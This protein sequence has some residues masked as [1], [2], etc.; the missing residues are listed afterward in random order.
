MLLGFHYSG[1][2]LSLWLIRCVWLLVL[3]CPSSAFAAI[4]PTPS[5][6]CVS[7]NGSALVTSEFPGENT[8]EWYT[9]QGVLLSIDQ[10]S[11][12]QSSIFNLCPGVYQVQYTNGDQNN[13]EWFS[14]DTPAQSAGQPGQTEIC[15]NTGTVN[16][17]SLI[18]GTPTGNG[19]WTNPFGQPHSGV[20]DSNGEVG[21]FY[22][23]TL[24]GATCNISSGVWVNVIQN[25]NPGLSATYLIC[26]TYEPFALTD[27]LAGTPEPNGQWFN[28]NQDPIDGNYYP[29]LQETELFTYMI[30][31]VEGCPAVF[32][33]LLVIENL[34]PNP[35]TDTEI[36]VCPGAV[37][38]DLTSYMEG[39]PDAGGTW[40][41]D[42]FNQIAIPFNPADNDEGLYQYIVPG[43]TPC[44]SQEAFLTLTYTDGI[45]AGVNS[46]LTVCEN[47]NSIS[48]TNSLDGNPSPG[49]Y[50]LDEDGN[51][52]DDIIQ[53]SAAPQ[54]VYTYTVE[55]V[56]C[57]PETSELVLTV[58]YL[59][60]AG[61]GGPQSFCETISEIDPFSLLDPLADGNG[62]W[63]INGIGLNGV[64][65]VQPDQQYD[66]LYS[67]TGNVCP[68]DQASYQI[69]VDP[70]P[71]ISGDPEL[72]LCSNS[73]VVSL[74]PYL[75]YDPQF[76][77][78]WLDSEGEV[79]DG[80]I[81]AGAAQ[82]GIYTATLYSDNACPDAQ[83]PVNLQIA[84][85]AFEDQE[86]MQ[87]DCIYDMT[88]DLNQLLPVDIPAGGVWESEE[89]IVDPILNADAIG[90]GSYTY[91]M[92]GPEACGASY[93]D[94]ELELTEA[95]S[96]GIGND[97]S[98]CSTSDVIDLEELVDGAEEG[99]YWTLNGEELAA[100]SFDPELE[101]SGL[102]YYTIPANGPCPADSSVV[103]IDVQEGLALSAGADQFLCEFDDPIVVGS[104]QCEECEFSWTPIDQIDDA[105]IA[106]PM[107]T[108]PAVNT[109][110]VFDLVV[111]ASN[112][113]CTALDEVAVTVY[114]DPEL[115]LTIPTALC[116]ED[117]LFA[118]AMGADSF[119]WMIEGE[120]VSED[121]V[122]EMIAD[123]PIDVT[124]VGTSSFGCSSQLESS[125]QVNPLIYPEF[126]LEPIEG[127]YPV[128][129]QLE[130]PEEED[131]VN[132]WWELGGVM[133]PQPSTTVVLNEPGEYDLSLFSEST[134]GC[135]NEVAQESWIE[136][137]GYPAVSFRFPEE[138]S[139][140]QTN[141]SFENLSEPGLEWNWDFGALGAS[142]E[143]EPQFTFP[144]LPDTGYLVCL[145]GTN[146]DGCTTQHCE[147][148]FFE[149]DMLV[150]VP[151]AFTPDLDGVNDVFRPY[152]SGVKEDTYVFQI[153]NRW[154]EMIFETN[155]VNAFW[156]GSVKGGS[157]FAPDGVY[158]WKIEVE[159]LYSA[160]KNL[161]QGHLTLLR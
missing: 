54:Q 161:F 126:N 131:G 38:F 16:L 142:N 15:S 48:L 130:L 129:V 147:S 41:D 154:G 94:L 66:L 33:T 67:V 140:Q 35:G 29:D 18:Q 96:P 139:F 101:S 114:P 109:T 102:Y 68:S 22:T 132:Y 87:Q 6:D 37:P 56:G 91:S 2:P 24:D 42:Q 105:S 28:S 111:E 62:E 135:I 72:A 61:A 160:E 81:D 40:Y 121:A 10:N 155:D 14:I 152:V 159:D 45:D 51:E 83:W 85:P 144:D 70:L 31:T 137:F 13:V 97:V 60:N 158:T 53:I 36:A 151:N 136:V 5:D 17:Q 74:T 23:Y 120:L 7:C 49:G 128:T 156:N 69:L 124:L 3:L 146:S 32:S 149:G 125:V 1:R 103:V 99:G 89:G 71:V 143:F 157:Y 78:E 112:G 82:E 50:W 141:V 11:F 133:Y 8:Y 127:C 100:T 21:G 104:L 117:V 73:G 119:E 39:Q 25:A 98:I 79:F 108:P 30:D 4:D 95:L 122:L 113:V 9:S 47:Q 64:L 44:P 123:Q 118:E 77:L 75:T 12:G 46:T 19:T 93:F 106:M 59:P 116:E 88:Y 20:F 43:A 63:S 107:F 90:N 148:I 76:T 134:F 145:E 65:Q 115:V 153:F 86:L 52:V 150:Y 92:Q 26:E 58:D 34:L 57:Q 138:L 80:A 55:A 110:T 27:V 84:D